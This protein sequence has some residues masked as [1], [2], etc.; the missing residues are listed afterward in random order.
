MNRRASMRRRKRS[1]AAVRCR[2]MAGTIR[3]SSLWWRSWSPRFPT[4]AVLRCGWS[5][6]SPPI[7]QRCARHRL[8]K[9]PVGVF[10][11]AELGRQAG[12]RLCRAGAVLAASLA[13]LWHSDAA[14]ELRAAA[15]AA[16]SLLA[17][18]YV[19]DYDLV[20]LAVAIGLFARH[21]LRQGFR[22]FEI[23]LLAA[24]WIMPLLSRGIADA[25]GIPLGLIVLLAF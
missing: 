23:S 13:W 24:A 19:L 4:P 2:S 10:R 17:T 25:T 7:S 12:N 20:V 11:S 9:N 16:G 14:F 22:D 8:G 3:R 18:P 6:A 15:L 1:S 5:R 21:G